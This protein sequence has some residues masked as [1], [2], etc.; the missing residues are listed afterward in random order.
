MKRR[1]GAPP[2]RG[3]VTQW[4]EWTP[5]KR[6]AQGSR[7]CGA[8]YLYLSTLKINLS[9]VHFFLDILERSSI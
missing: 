2:F 3:P 5:T 1:D 7:P 9:R 8:V 6:Q 4:T